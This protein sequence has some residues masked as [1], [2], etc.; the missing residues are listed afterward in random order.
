LESIELDD[1]GNSVSV[2]YIAYNAKGQCT[3]VIYG[4][5]VMTRYRYDEKTLRLAR[6]RSEKY[7]DKT[8][9]SPLQLI[10]RPLGGSTSQ[11][12]LFQDFS[13][14]Y[15]LVGNILKIHDRT[16]KS[17][18]SNTPG[19]I[20]GLDRVFTYDSLYRLLSATGRECTYGLY[21]ELPP[22]W[23]EKPKCVDPTLTR[24]Y[25]QEY[26]YDS[27]GNMQSLKHY[28]VENATERGFTRKFTLPQDGENAQKTNRLS[29][30]TVRDKTMYSYAYDK[31]GNL[32][33]EGSLQ[34]FEWDHGD[35]VRAF[36]IRSGD[37]GASN[38]Y[39]HYLYD[40]TGQ[41]VK[42]L[43]RIS[44]SVYRVT[45]YIDGVFEYHG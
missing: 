40:S 18:V 44:D 41:R 21:N 22:P 39:T 34:H 8:I 25:T 19:G 36:Y 14:D 45:V 35:H 2:K 30:L 38:D 27:V 13:Y 4:N 1:G 43:V 10:Y 42:K 37:T 28:I 29:T 16:P 32:I 3:L 5:T 6:T 11:G 26:R 17:G 20:Y 12:L 31:S 7:E 33:E 23:L 24:A 15:D 9:R